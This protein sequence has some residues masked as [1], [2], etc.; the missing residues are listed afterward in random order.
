MTKIKIER[1]PLI[2]WDSGVRKTIKETQDFIKDLQDAINKASDVDV[3]EALHDLTAKTTRDF[4]MHQGLHPKASVAT[5]KWLQ[6]VNQRLP[7][8]DEIKAAYQ[9]NPNAFKDGWYW[10]ETTENKFSQYNPFFD[11]TR[12]VT[13][14]DVGHLLLVVR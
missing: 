11:I 6:S 12:H 4:R 14:S 7:S 8:V 2:S 10:F 9:E 5:D 1:T 3:D 13:P